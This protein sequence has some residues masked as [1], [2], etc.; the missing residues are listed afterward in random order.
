MRDGTAVAEAIAHK[1]SPTSL[2]DQLMRE[3]LR[4]LSEHA[5]QM[6]AEKF[7]RSKANL[8]VTRSVRV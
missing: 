4:V 6:H 7:A 2:L 5:A 1:D 8:C 3:Q